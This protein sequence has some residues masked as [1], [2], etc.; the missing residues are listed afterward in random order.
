MADNLPSPSEVVDMYHSNGITS[1]R[2]YDP[3]PGVLKNS[4]ISVALGVRNEDVQAIASSPAA[5]DGWISV[6]VK[7][8]LPQCQSSIS[9]SAM[10]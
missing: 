4:G 8:M 10:R 3:N 1:L 7:L 2:L 5:A 6:N 9:R